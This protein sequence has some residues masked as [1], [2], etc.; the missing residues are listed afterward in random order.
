VCAKD[1][2]HRLTVAYRRPVIVFSARSQGAAL[3]FLPSIRS[4]RRI[5]VIGFNGVAAA[6]QTDYAMTIDEPASR[7]AL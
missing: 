3:A 6:V 7:E 1:R 2:L 5:S 4:P